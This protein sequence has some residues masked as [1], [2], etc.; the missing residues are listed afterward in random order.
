[1]LLV[2]GIVSDFIGGGIKLNL[3]AFT[4]TYEIFMKQT[5]KAVSAIISERPTNNRTF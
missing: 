3:T 5:K 1:M 2:N 4:D